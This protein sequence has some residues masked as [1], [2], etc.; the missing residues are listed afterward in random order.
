MLE[1]GTY[2][3]GTAFGLNG[4]ATGELCFNTGMTGYQEV[5]LTHHIL[6]SAYDNN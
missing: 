3:Y 5:L 2:F 4:I 1:D 6:A